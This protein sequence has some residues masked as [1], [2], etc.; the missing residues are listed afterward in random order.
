MLC[1]S[2]EVHSDILSVHEGPLGDSNV[3][4]FDGAQPPGYMSTM[5][6]QSFACAGN[7]SK[8][9]PGWSLLNKSRASLRDHRPTDK[10]SSDTLA[11]KGDKPRFS[12]GR[13]GCERTF[14]RK[15]DAGR[16]FRQ[17]HD[18]ERLKCEGCDKTFQRRDQL[19]SHGASYLEDVNVYLM[20]L[21]RC[22]DCVTRLT[23]VDG[24]LILIL[25]T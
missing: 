7:Q 22:S 8:T 13:P 1:H 3:S 15:Y 19:K 18:G 6:H 17:V 5:D 23:S 4:L 21:I 10:L 11:L 9:Y 16:H 12:C 25:P 2:R 24:A 14:S 20:W